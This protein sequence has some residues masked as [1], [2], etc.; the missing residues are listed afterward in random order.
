[1]A[2]EGRPYRY[3]VPAEVHELIEREGI[4]TQSRSGDMVMS[5]QD[6]EEAQ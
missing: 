5:A 4:Y 1:M 3:L 6:Q 2:A